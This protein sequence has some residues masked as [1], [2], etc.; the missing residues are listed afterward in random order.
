MFRFTLPQDLS[1]RYRRL[2][3]QSRTRFT[4]RIGSQGRSRY[5]RSCNATE[6]VAMDQPGH[7]KRRKAAESHDR[8]IAADAEASR[9]SISDVRKGADSRP[10]RR[11]GRSGAPGLLIGGGAALPSPEPVPL[12]NAIRCDRQSP[13]GRTGSNNANRINPQGSRLGLPSDALLDAEET[14]NSDAELSPT[15]PFD[16]IVS[17]WAS[18]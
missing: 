8:Q 6:P 13:R 3:L 14:L 2:Q 15:P 12:R 11:C 17:A 10:P 9:T 16:L 4:K 1:S 18:V 7:E 5:L